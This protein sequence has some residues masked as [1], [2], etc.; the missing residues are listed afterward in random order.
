MVKREIFFND[1]LNEYS[2]EREVG[3]I[4]SYKR[5]PMKFKLDDST[6]KYRSAILKKEIEEN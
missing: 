4:K 2:M 5:V 6:A 3:G 1:K